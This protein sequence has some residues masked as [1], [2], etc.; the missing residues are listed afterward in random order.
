VV[1]EDAPAGVAA[2]KEAGMKVLAVPT[3]HESSALRDADLVLGSMRE[4]NEY[5][6]KRS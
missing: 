3:T 6:R 5:L 1:V 4:V 2:A